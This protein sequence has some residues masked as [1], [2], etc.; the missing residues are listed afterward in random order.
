MSDV[1]AL[2]QKLGYQFNN[3]ELLE[4]AL[5]H[6]SMQSINNE[7]LEFLGDG[8][9]NFLVAVE[10]YQTCKQANEGDLSR[11]RASLVKGETLAQLAKELDLGQYLRLGAGEVRSGGHLRHSMLADAVEAIIGAIY[12]DSGIEQCQACLVKWY[13]GRIAEAATRT[14]LKDPKT[15][16]QELLQ[17]KKQSLP[18]YVITSRQGKSHEQI[19]EVQCRVAALNLTTQAR[20]D[21]RRKAEQT[22]AQAMLEELQENQL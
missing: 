20:A 12:L 21:S 3:V 9:L 17:A 14:N 13:G 15:A 5:T 10:L 6:R 19:F 18:V 22:A 2:M 4:A 1:K 8:L 16:L 7:R 11:L